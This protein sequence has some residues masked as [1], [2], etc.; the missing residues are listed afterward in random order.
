MAIQD[1]PHKALPVSTENTEKGAAP[2][3]INPRDQVFL[4]TW[5]EGS[6][7]DQPLPKW[8]GPL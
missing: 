3:Q 2:S 1:Y 5:E 4:K 8:K 7:D 6:A